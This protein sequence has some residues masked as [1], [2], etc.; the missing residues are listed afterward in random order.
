[1]RGRVVQPR[2]KHDALSALSGGSLLGQP[3]QPFLRA[4]RG[5]QYAEPYAD[6]VC[7]VPAGHIRAGGMGKLS[8]VPRGALHCKSRQRKLHR[9][10]GGRYGQCYSDGMYH[11]P[12]RCILAAG[13]FRLPAVP[14]WPFQQ[15]QRARG[16]CAVRR[17]QIQRRDGGCNQLPSLPVPQS[18]MACGAKRLRS[19]RRGLDVDEHGDQLHRVRAERGALQPGRG[20]RRYGAPMPDVSKG[21]VCSKT[22]Y[23]MHAVRD[24]YVRG[25]LRQH[26][27][28]RL[29]GNGLRASCRGVAVR[30]TDGELCFALP[31]RRSERA[32]RVIGKMKMQAVMASL[33]ARCRLLA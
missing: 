6:R 18:G 23:R 19:V 11:V 28:S 3:R 4:V 20:G 5:G 13:I 32:L 31:G 26:G 15:R 8:A 16:V 25:R 33:L 29:R 9:M 7:N 12:Q 14:K 30:Y 21:D 1:M 24:Q 22:H 2:G 10:R 17:G 27:V